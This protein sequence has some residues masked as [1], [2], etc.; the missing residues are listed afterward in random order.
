MVQ[1]IMEA[2]SCKGCG[3]ES[4][5]EVLARCRQCRRWPLRSDLY[6]EEIKT[7]PGRSLSLRLRTAYIDNH[8]VYGDLCAKT[9]ISIER[10]K[11][12]ANGDVPTGVEKE[13][14]EEYV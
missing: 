4:G 7:M 6:I 13:K 8:F 14:L 10:I 5:K 1:I 12:I 11:A 3:Y 9:G 2:P